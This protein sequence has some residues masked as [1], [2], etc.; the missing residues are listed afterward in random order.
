N[1]DIVEAF[2]GIRAKGHVATLRN[3]LSV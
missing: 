2:Y 3:T 1:G